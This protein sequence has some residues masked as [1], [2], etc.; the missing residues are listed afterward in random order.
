MISS[1]TKQLVRLHP[2]RRHLMLLVFLAVVIYAV[3]PQLGSFR[4]SLGIIQHATWQPLLL[5]ITLTATSYLA[6]AGTYCWLAFHRLLYGRTVL[7]QLASMFVNR[8][9]PGGS[10]AVGVNY[11]YLR[12]AKHTAAEAAAVV[13]ANNLLGLVGHVL[14]F[15]SLLVLFHQHLPA[16]QRGVHT[17]WLVLVW[18]G[19]GLLLV[20]VLSVQK[21]RRWLSRSAGALLR[22][23]ASYRQRPL[24]LLAAL[25][26]SML[27]TLTTVGSLYWA[28]V[29]VGIHLSF[30]TVMIV[31]S[32]GLS[33]GTATPSP[34]GLGGQEA[35][36]VTGLLAYHVAA[37]AALGAVL[38]YRLISYWLSLIVGAGAFGVVQQRH[39]LK[40]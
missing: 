27:V 25:G 38:L 10:G 1:M 23:L 15:S 14:A 12:R 9:L 6:A 40:T 3:V 30:V 35:G 13:A 4:N 17:R 21:W 7:L 19:C 39:L 16:M 22:Q 18:L 32:I 28:L 36:L 24:A 11:L 34:G 33:I 26:T 29:A 20:G 37:P 2:G 31:F 8:I 5:A